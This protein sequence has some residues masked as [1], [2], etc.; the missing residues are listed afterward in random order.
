MVR[1]WDDFR[2]TQNSLKHPEPLHVRWMK[3][4]TLRE[5]VRVRACGVVLSAHLLSHS[6]SSLMS[7]REICSKKNDW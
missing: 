2:D 5:N 7:G 1:R 6:R 4:D 3:C